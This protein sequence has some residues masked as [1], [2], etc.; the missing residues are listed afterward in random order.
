MVVATVA[1]KRDARKPG[2]SLSMGYGF[3][4]FRSAESAQTAI[5][6]L[7]GSQLDGHK[8][9]LKLSERTTHQYVPLLEPSYL[10]SAR[11]NMFLSIL[12]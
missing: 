12:D 10:S 9:E 3:V 4:Q 11:Q 6:E 1:R 5:K 7:Q 8:L 2:E